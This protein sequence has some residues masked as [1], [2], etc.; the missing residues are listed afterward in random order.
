MAN[1]YAGDDPQGRLPSFAAPGAGGNAW[2]V[3]PAMVPGLDLYGL[4]VPMWFCPVRPNEFDDGTINSADGWFFKKKRRHINTT[5]DL[6]QYLTAAFGA[7]ALIN[8]DWW[9]PRNK[10]TGKNP[11]QLYPAPGAGGGMQTPNGLSDPGWPVKTTD[12]MITSTQPII[13]DYCVAPSSSTDITGILPTTAHFNNG[14]LSS[15][16]LGFADGHVELHSRSAIKWQY[17]AAN[18]TFY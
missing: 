3:G 1:L 5:A 13:S 16:N 17:T 15:I 8:H 7:W 10:A 9:V 2:D 6:N 12:R 4:S 11:P 14:A 18:S